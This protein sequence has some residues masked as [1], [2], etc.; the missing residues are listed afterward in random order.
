M[1]THL[2]QLRLQDRHLGFHCLNGSSEMGKGGDGGTKNHLPPLRSVVHFTNENPIGKPTL[3]R[4]TFAT[5][6]SPPLSFRFLPVKGEGEEG[7]GQPYRF[8]LH[9]SI[10]VKLLLKKDSEI[11][12]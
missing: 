6:A 7:S 5:W 12:N 4:P 8:G 9:S 11:D 1:S 3:L 10:L 2:L